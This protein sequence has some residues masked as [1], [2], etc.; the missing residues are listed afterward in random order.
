MS[1]DTY[2]R[3]WQ[4]RVVSELNTEPDAP[5]TSR[6]LLHVRVVFKLG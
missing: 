6:G 5:S 4:Y 3:T 1:D 2:G